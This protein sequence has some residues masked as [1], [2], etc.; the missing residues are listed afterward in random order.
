MGVALLTARVNDTMLTARVND[1]NYWVVEVIVGVLFNLSQTDKIDTAVLTARVNDTELT[2][3]TLAGTA[4]GRARR[5]WVVELQE[6][7]N[8]GDEGVGA[9]A[10]C[11]NLN[12][13]EWGTVCVCM[14][15][16]GVSGGGEW[17][18]W[19]GGMCV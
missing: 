16:G 13:C 6:G 5:S 11:V 4:A 10:P 7:A 12:K 1:T 18:G 17:G 2:A 9:D 14:W 3:T 15:G 19:G 8:H